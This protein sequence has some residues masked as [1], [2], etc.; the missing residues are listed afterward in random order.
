VDHQF[1]PEPL[2]ILGHN[3]N[4]LEEVNAALDQ[5]ANAVEIDVTAY[6]H[7]LNALCIDHAG[8]MGDDPG[9]A[10]APAFE[11]FLREL[12]EVVDR[13]PELCMVELDLKPP[14]SRPELGPVLLSAIRGILTHG[15][16]LSVILSVA[17][18]TT[19]H[20]DRPTA[21]S[22]F[23]RISGDVR[24]REGFMI[25]SDGNVDG[26]AEFFTR[27]LKVTRFGYG[28]GTSLPL[29]DESMMVYRTPIEKACWMRAVR[30]VP[31]FVEAWTVNSLD[32]L[33]LYLRL[34]V[35]GLIC[36]RE[37]IERVRDLLRNSELGKRYRLATRLDDPMAPD[38]FAYGLTVVTTRKDLAG[39][40]ASITFT[41]S[42]DRG[43]AS[44]T[45]DTSLNRR[46][47]SGSTSFVVLYSADLGTLRSIT[48]QSDLGHLAPGWHLDSI[49]VESSRYGGKKTARFD[50]WIASADPVTRELG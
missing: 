1:G 39:T 2:W 36:D 45:V 11:P 19:S 30:G 7:D 32:N 29:V 28:N 35:N 23:D 47:E 6:A 31:G 22:V 21:S 12:R 34:G 33:Q 13:R 37:G 5:G 42:G 18:V 43:A 14:G 40:D 3:T 25:D 26:V 10:S 50:T 4:S 38:N 48:V 20:A 16:T 49:V 41:L 46:M 8:I 15:T 44:T 27:K 24:A 9:H 17:D